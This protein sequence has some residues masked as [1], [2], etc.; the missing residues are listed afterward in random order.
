M[1]NQIQVPKGFEKTQ[2]EAYI[3]RLDE[4]YEKMDSYSDETLLEAVGR[5]VQILQDIIYQ[6]KK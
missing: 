2:F 4:L 3:N 6:S 1:D 5:E